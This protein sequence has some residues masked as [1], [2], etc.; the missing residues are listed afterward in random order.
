LIYGGAVMLLVLP[1]LIGAPQPEVYASAA[2]Q[3]LAHQF[4]WATTFVNVVFWLTLG[5]ASALSF[6]ALTPQA[7]AR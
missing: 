2:P 5:V 6:R 4:V 7:G 1:H 3:A